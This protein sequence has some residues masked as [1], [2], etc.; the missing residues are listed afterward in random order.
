M[1]VPDPQVSQKEDSGEMLWATGTRG[2]LASLPACGAG[3]GERGN[4]SSQLSRLHREGDLTPL[5]TNRFQAFSSG[6]YDVT[7]R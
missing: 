6:L 2:P 5:S 4:Y 7:K 1:S 3:R